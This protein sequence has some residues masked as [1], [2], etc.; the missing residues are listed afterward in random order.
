MSITPRCFIVTQSSY[1]TFR[2]GDAA[3]NCGALTPQDK[4]IARQ[5]VCDS[6]IKG[7]SKVPLMKTKP[8]SPPR[9]TRH[10]EY[11]HKTRWWSL[12]VDSYYAQPSALL[13]HWHSSQYI[14]CNIKR[15]PRNER[16]TDFRALSSICSPHNYFFSNFKLLLSALLLSPHWNDW[17]REH[18][19]K[20]LKGHLGI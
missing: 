12:E 20:L 1:L 18:D 13:F 9:V 2:F 17:R 7:P 6:K 8:R 15:K 4:S 14:D 19:L 5:Q 10:K 3:A 11:E 16:P